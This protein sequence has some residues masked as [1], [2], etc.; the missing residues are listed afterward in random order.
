MSSALSALLLSI[1][2]SGAADER[3]ICVPQADG[4][5]WDCGKGANAPAPRALPRARSASKSTPPPYLVDPSRVYPETGVTD[6]YRPPASPAIT[7][8]PRAKAPAA[9]ASEPIVE[10]IAKAAERPVSPPAAQQPTAALPPAAPADVE[11]PLVKPE[12]VASPTVIAPKAPSSAPQGVAAE[13]NTSRSTADF[14]ALPGSAFT[15][16][17]A[18]ARSSSGFAELVLNL[19]LAAA[20]TYTI[21]V[22]RAD[23]AWW[24]LLWRDFPDLQRARSAAAGLPGSFWPRRLA[25][26]QA[27]MRASSP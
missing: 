3:I 14:L 1:S 24:L 22:R 26:L 13:S 6:S 16:Q 12:P 23:E 19:G 8:P 21:R 20:D 7:A 4:N 15:V 9:P 18:A 27:E 25:P 17:L 5:G 2:L 10:P 11:R